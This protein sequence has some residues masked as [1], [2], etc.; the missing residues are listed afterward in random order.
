MKTEIEVSSWEEFEAR[1]RDIR[2][3]Q[4]GQ[5]HACNLLYRGQHNAT[6]DLMTSLEKSGRTLT[7]LE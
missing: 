7:V 1:L 3:N 2:N 5:G 4:T 6:W